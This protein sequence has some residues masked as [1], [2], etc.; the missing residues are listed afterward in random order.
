MKTRF[1]FTCSVIALSSF[2]LQGCTSV[3]SAFS[4]FALT[5][6]YAFNVA[7]KEKANIIEQSSDRAAEKVIHY[8]ET[9]K[10]EHE[11]V[12]SLKLGK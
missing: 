1:L 9:H 12:N 7:P 3:M 5:S 8:L 10:R 4:G 2:L 6:G 11:E